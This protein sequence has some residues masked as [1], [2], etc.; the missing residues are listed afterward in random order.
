MKQNEFSQDQNQ[1]P[2]RTSR[3]TVIADSNQSRIALAPSRDEV[4]RRAYFSYLNEG[5]LPGR[6]EKHWLEAE[7]Q[8]LA[9]M[10]REAQRHLGSRRS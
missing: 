6:D 3:P 2:A 4:A 9:E 1:K 8:L 7:A 5:S 10:A